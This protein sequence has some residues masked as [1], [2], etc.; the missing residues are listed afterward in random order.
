MNKIF[1]LLLS[2]SFI[3]PSFAASLDEMLAGEGNKA[4]ARLDAFLLK[5][6]VSDLNA[7]K[8]DPKKVCEVQSY[9]AV[10]VLAEKRSVQ[11]E[12]N[13]DAVLSVFLAEEIGGT[14]GPQLNFGFLKG[15]QTVELINLVNV[16]SD[17]Q[18]RLS[19]AIPGMI[20]IS[21]KKCRFILDLKKPFE[22]FGRAP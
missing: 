6:K 14:H 20:G 18:I 15:K 5:N 13:G 11:L 16:P 10:A 8:S 1:C 12:K 9:L 22:I 3:S 2:V 19:P 17:W 4:L 7:I 21:G